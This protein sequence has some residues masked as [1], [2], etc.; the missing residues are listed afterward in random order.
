[1][2]SPYQ[3]TVGNQS[4]W[5]HDDGFSAGVFHTYDGLQVAGPNDEPRKVHVF[6]PRSYN[7]SQEG[8]PVVYMNDGETAFYP[9]GV[10]N[11]C[12]H[13][14]EALSS[15]YE[16]KAIPE[17]IVVAMFPFD[18]EY[19]YTHVDWAPG[20]PWGGLANYAE[21]VTQYVKPF[22]DRSYKT[23]PGPRTT[24]T[25]GS[26]HGGLASFYMAGVH[27]E[28]YGLAGCLSS[29]FWVGLDPVDGGPYDSPPLATS[30]L[31][32]RS[33]GALTRREGRPKL[34]V[35]WGL[36]RTGGSWNLHVEG[37]AT[38]RG[39]EMVSLLQTSYGYIKGHDLDWYEDPQG[40]HDE[41]SWTRRFPMLMRHLLGDADQTH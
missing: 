4:A 26:S 36:V 28:V 23:K 16:A 15:L 13:V 27:P 35:D 31:L 29:S 39:R 38:N 22:I 33:Q 19:E 30:E 5:F 41:D 21:Y 14:A 34:W 9:G 2:P 12:W 1:M 3:L 18:R 11:K 6:I 32:K 8:Y 17:V 37:A 7:Q 20:R 10:A 24:M 40:Q 25:L